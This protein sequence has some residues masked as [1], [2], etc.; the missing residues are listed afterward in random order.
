MTRRDA[1]LRRVYGITEEDYENILLNQGGGCGICGK[2]KEQEGKHLAVDHDHV[3]RLVRGILC[4]YCNYRLL[5]RHRDVDLLRRM[6]SY[7]ETA[8]TFV[9]PKK[10]KRKKRVRKCRKH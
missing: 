4:G 2:T 1:Y 10:P 6:A 3:T 5:R 9:V 8:T 7:L